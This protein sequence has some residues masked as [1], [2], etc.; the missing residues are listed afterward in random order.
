MEKILR[1]VQ[2]YCSWEKRV[3]QLTHLIA[4]DYLSNHQC[5]LLKFSRLVQHID[6]NKRCKYYLAILNSSQVVGFLLINNNNL[7]ISVERSPILAPSQNYC[8]RDNTVAAH[9]PSVVI[10]V[11]ACTV[12][13]FDS[14]N[15]SGSRDSGYA[16]FQSIHSNN[17]E[18]CLS[19]LEESWLVGDQLTNSVTSTFGSAKD[20]SF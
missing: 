13:W 2:L 10:A 17:F 20:W 8:W 19:T 16:N 12:T 6:C 11:H 14:D 18:S 3:W 1:H 5:I 9:A 15:Q 4:K 7:I